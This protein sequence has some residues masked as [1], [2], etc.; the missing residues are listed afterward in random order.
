MKA[1]RT[2]AYRAMTE[3]AGLKL[4]AVIFAVALYFNARG[5]T[6]RE[7]DIDVPI[8]V[9]SYPT[10]QVLLSQPPTV[11]RARVKGNVERLTEALA[12]RT[13]YD[14]DL[15]SAED[16]RAIVFEPAAIES[17]LG[18]GVTVL[19][20]SPGKFDVKLD[21]VV[22]KRVPVALEIV[23]EPGPN[24][25]L[26]RERGAI[27]P[28]YVQIRGAKTIVDDIRQ[29]HTEPLDLSGSTADFVAKVGLDNRP[30][31]SIKEKT[32][33][34]RLPIFER[35]GEKELPGCKIQVRN[36][37]DGFVCE[38]SPTFYRARV[39]GKKRMVDMITVENI[40][41]YVFVDA[42]RLPIEKELLQRQFAAVE[43]TIGKLKD[44]AISLTKVRYFN[45]T[46]T[47]R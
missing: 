18:G 3:N 16:G 27:E 47:R 9:I 21:E 12:R 41:N 28:R 10:S 40:S 22:D 19:S 42:S 33:Q 13:P 25:R 14:I 30:G 44:A 8:N 37:P 35:S 6:V 11:L 20:I 46:V 26:D 36:C 39:E 45:I 23:K 34:V 15:S 38:A 31:V 43:P 4:V 7:L 2:F 1:L 17:H 29:V 32:V 5:E 24:Y